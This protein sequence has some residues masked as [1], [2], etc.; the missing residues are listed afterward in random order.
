MS[1]GRPSPCS[2]GSLGLKVISMISPVSVR[3]SMEI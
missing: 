3:L 2:Q 1:D